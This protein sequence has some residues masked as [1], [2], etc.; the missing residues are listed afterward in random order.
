MDY[1]DLVALQ[2]NPS[3]GSQKESASISRKGTQALIRELIR[4]SDPLKFPNPALVALQD[5]IIKT[6][7][8]NIKSAFRERRNCA[9]CDL[10]QSKKRSQ[11]VSL[12]Y[13]RKVLTEQSTLTEDMFFSNDERKRK[14]LFERIAG[15]LFQHHKSTQFIVAVSYHGPNSSGIRDEKEKFLVGKIEY[16]LINT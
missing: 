8:D 14:F 3:A 12:L 4:Q 2:L 5:K 7:C 15:G 11:G 1:F 6:D 16:C 13:D 10:I 9:E